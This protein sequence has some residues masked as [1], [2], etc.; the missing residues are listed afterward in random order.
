MFFKIKLFLNT[1]M[2][3]FQ[4]I[5][6]KD[7]IIFATKRNSNTSSL[8]FN[9]F[10]FAQKIIPTGVHQRCLRPR[11]KCC[12]LMFDSTEPFLVGDSKFEIKFTQASCQSDDVIY[13]AQCQLCS[14]FY[15]GQSINQLNIRVNG[16]RGKFKTDKFDKSALSHH[17]YNDH[18][19]GIDKGLDN[20]KFAIVEVA[21]PTALDRKEDYYIW[22]T[23]ATARHLNRYKV[24]R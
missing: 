19:D 18:V 3:D 15:F 1:R 10:G 16:H 24:V 2:D 22:S 12:K 4:R 7:N 5:T 20:Y 21:T 17:I 11:C 13:F 14:D 9:K 8:L 6:A 23:D